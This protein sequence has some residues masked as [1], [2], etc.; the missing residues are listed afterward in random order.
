MLF[1]ARQI[2]EVGRQRP[3]RVHNAK[4]VAMIGVRLVANTG[5]NKKVAEFLASPDSSS[6]LESS[7]ERR[8]PYPTPA[9]DSPR[10]LTTVQVRERLG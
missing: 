2:I 8:G 6:V 9:V 3:F 10:Q 4:H 5:W 7:R 1:G